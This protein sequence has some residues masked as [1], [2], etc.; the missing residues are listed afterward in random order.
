MTCEDETVAERVKKIA[1][2]GIDIT[3]DGAEYTP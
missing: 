1:D 3:Y 2:D